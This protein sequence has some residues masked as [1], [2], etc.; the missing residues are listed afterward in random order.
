[1]LRESDEDGFEPAS[2]VL[3]KK[4]KS[5]A[6]K[7]P[8]R[9]WYNEKMDQPHEQLC[10]KLCFRD[11]HQFRDALLNLHITQARNFRYHRNSDQRIIA[12]CKQEHCQ[13]CIVAAVIKGEKTFAIKK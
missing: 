12:C 7:R 4:R 10:M 13:F 6:K 9:K 3:P 2:F 1:M 5:R 8:A 11:Q